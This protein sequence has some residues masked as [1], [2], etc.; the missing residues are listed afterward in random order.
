MNASVLTNADLS[1]LL[2]AAADEETGHRATALGRA[3][4]NAMTA[5][6]E[7]AAEV[8]GEGRSL[9]DLP[10]VGPWVARRIHEWLDDP[11]SV[12]EPPPLRRGF[13]TLS[14]VRATLEAN[15]EWVEGI[16]G[17][18]QMHTT[19]SDG[20]A[21]VEEMAGHCAARGYDF[22]AITDHSQSLKIAKGQDEAKLAAAGEEL[23]RVN[24]KLA[25]EGTELRLLKGIEMDLD[26]EGRGDM[27]PAA[28]RKLDLVLGAF[29][30]KLRLEEDQ[31]DRY[32]KALANPDVNVIAHPRA[33]KFGR[34]LGLKADWE[35]VVEAAAAN[36]KALEIDAYPDRQDLDVATLELAREAGCRISI[37]TDAHYPWELT[38]MPFGLAAAILAGVPRER[39]LN[40]Q[41]VED[42]VAWA[43][44]GREP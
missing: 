31:T 35:R 22:V 43:R 33:R 36:D 5:W 42:V 27:E 19:F 8:A 3:S 14:T 24:A 7:E 12:E 34:R 25:A 44:Q 1:E 17:D 16:R 18:L 40:F 21:T 26:S 13:L 20:K 29:H 9:T 37:G 23:D 6:V 32:L 10:G 15:P 38:V 39:I 2:S 28:L 4:R 41:P 30:T 11:P